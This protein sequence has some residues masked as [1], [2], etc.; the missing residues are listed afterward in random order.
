MTWPT[1]SSQ[2]A[3]FSIHQPPQPAHNRVLFCWVGG[4]GVVGD[5]ATAVIRFRCAE[6]GKLTKPFFGTGNRWILPELTP[7]P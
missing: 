3:P 6:I 4:R 1:P 5:E 7:D 2:F